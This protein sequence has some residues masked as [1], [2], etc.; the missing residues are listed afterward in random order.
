MLKFIPGILILQVVTIALVLVGRSD[1]ADWGWLRM[2]IPI[3]VAGLLTAFWFGSIA[4]Q[5]FK[6]DI[7]RLKEKHAKERENIRVNAERAKTRLVKQTQRKTRQKARRSSL[8]SNFKVGLAFAG[9]AGLGAVL[10]LT[11]FMSLGLLILTTAGGA[12]GGYLM[13]IRQEKRK[14]QLPFNDSAA[15]PLVDAT[16]GKVK[17][18]LTMRSIEKE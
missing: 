3:L 14:M 10:V 9:A 5:R 11:Q 18:L 8:Q 15:P 16:P 13:R 7:S 2:A 12:L 6:D 4:A 1:M 17:Q